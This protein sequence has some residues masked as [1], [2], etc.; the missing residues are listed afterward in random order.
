M[1]SVCWPFSV[2]SFE[3][4]Q[5]RR[6]PVCFLR[7]FD[8]KNSVCL[9]LAYLSYRNLITSKTWISI[10]FK[11]WPET[12]QIWQPKHTRVIFSDWIIMCTALPDAG[13][14]NL[15]QRRNQLQL[16]QLRQ[17]GEMQL[18]LFEFFSYCL[19]VKTDF[20]FIAGHL[21]IHRAA[22]IPVTPLKDSTCCNIL[23]CKLCLLIKPM[24]L[25]WPK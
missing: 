6:K 9:N 2:G 23:F 8:R 12:F 7:G 25:K 13:G 10:E 18:T 5:S 1:H 22:N 16:Y 21:S 15:F 4:F 17:E 14:K 19:F 20:V 11:S 3:T 24:I